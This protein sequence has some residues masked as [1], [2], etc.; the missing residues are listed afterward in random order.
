MGE[1]LALDE[2]KTGKISD[3]SMGPLG[4]KDVSP[5]VRPFP[6]PDWM[7]IVNQAYFSDELLK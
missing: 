5:L 2:P 4:D 1:V 3:G 7:Q 6:C